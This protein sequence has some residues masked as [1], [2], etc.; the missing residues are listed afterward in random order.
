ME[1]RNNRQIN[2]RDRLLSLTATG[3]FL[4]LL[5][6]ADRF[7][8]D[9]EIRILINCAIFIGLAVSYNLING[10]TGQ[11]SLAPNA[12]AAIGAYTSALLTM[13]PLEKEL[14]FIVK[15]LIWP[16]SVLHAPFIVSLFIAGLVTAF[17]AFLMGFPVFRVRG[18]YLAIVTLG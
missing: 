8:S 7:G 4:F 10:V 5:F 6:L 17:M 12:F 11:F 16:L 1:L 3:V 9:Y 14:S 2:R 15:P 18:D 13:T